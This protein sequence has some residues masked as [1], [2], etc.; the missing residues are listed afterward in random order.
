MRESMERLDEINE[1]M[2]RA[3]PIL[4]AGAGA[5]ARPGLRDAL[6]GYFAERAGRDARAARAAASRAAVEEA[7]EEAMA[8]EKGPAAGGGGPAGSLDG[9]CE[10]APDDPSAPRAERLG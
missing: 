1:R 10:P 3:L 4:E 9:E 8:R 7:M 2:K 5:H 6:G